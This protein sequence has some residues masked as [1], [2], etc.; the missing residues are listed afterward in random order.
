[1]VFNLFEAR[2][3][4]LAFNFIHSKILLRFFLRAYRLEK[5]EYNEVFTYCGFALNNYNSNWQLEFS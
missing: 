2:F 1:M 3:S 5:S 4:D